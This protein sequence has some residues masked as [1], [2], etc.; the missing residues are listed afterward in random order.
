M[1]SRFG[2]GTCSVAPHR[3][4]I[5]CE[6]HYIAVPLLHNLRHVSPSELVWSSGWQNLQISNRFFYIFCKIAS[7]LIRRA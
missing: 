5:R 1:L 3:T 6:L 4:R 7:H 2:R